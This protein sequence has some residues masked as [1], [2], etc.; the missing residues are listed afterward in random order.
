MLR[1]PSRNLFDRP[2]QSGLGEL[3]EAENEVH[4]DVAD[5]GVAKDAEGL[6]RVRGVMT[7]VGLGCILVAAVLDAVAIVSIRALMRGIV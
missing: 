3:R 5:S 6:T 7:P 4:A 1:P 2:G